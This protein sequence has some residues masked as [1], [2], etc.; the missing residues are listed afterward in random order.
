MALVIV[1]CML[2]G[3][4][5]GTAA[6][7][8]PVNNYAPE[9]VGNP[10]IGERLVCGA[11]SWTGPVSEFSYV[12]LR[13]AIP[14]GSGV[15]YTVTAADAGHSL[16][17]VVTA[18]GGGGSAEAES[19]NSLAIPGGKP[20]RP[21]E[22]IV[23]PEVSG[24]PALGETLTCLTGTWSGSPTPTFT[25]LWVREKGPN[26][27]IIESATASTYKVVSEDEGHSLACEV[28]ATNSS[29]SSSKLSSNE[30]P[31]SGT[32]PKDIVAPKLLGVEP[33]AVGESLTCSPGTWSGNPTPAFTYQWLRDGTN[34]GSA[35]GSTYMVE[36]ADQLHSLS[37]EVIATNIAGS[38][39]AV[40][41]VI[42]IRGRE[43]GNI[44]APRIS[45][46]PA[47]GQTLTCNEGAWTGVPAPTIAY[48]WVRDQGTPGEVAIGGATF[49]TYLVG[50]EDR[51]H[52][53]SCDVTATNSEGH[54]SQSSEPVVVPAGE[55]GGSPPQSTE[56][57]SVSGK[58]AAGET[59]SCSTGTWSGS[60][61]PTLTYQWLRDGSTI[62][63]ATTSSHVVVEAD[64]GH[65]LSCKVTA[66]NNE[67]VASENSSPLEI[68]GSAPENLKE[69]QVY[70]TPAVGE[71][72]ACLRGTW[73]GSPTPTFTYLWVRDE[74]PNETI[75]E[76]ATASTY[77]VGSEDE[78]HSLACEVTATNSAGSASK[79]SKAIL[80]PGRGPENIEAPRISGTP[81][82]G[83]TLTC[84][85]GEWTGQPTPT[86]AYRWLLN[87]ETVPTATA[88][89]FTVANADRGL[90]LSCKVIATNREGTGSA[91]SA[92]LHVPGSRPQDIE[93]PQVSGTA[94][95]GQQLTCQR[96]IWNGEPPPAFTYQ[97]LRDGT[98]IASATSSTYTVELADEGHRL[99]CEVTATNSEGRT[100]ALSGNSLTISTGTLGAESTPTL[101][102]PPSA[103]AP[104]PPTAAQILAAV[105]AQLAHA[106]RRARVTLLRKTGLYA[107]SFT[108][109]VAGRLELFWYLAP[110]GKSH[111]AKTKP[112][113]LA[114]A[115]ATFAGPGTKK[116]TLR[117]TSAGRSLVAHNAR[118][119][120]MAKGAFVRPHERPMT[121]GE[122]VLVSH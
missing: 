73:S 13:D 117:L 53:L 97:W 94:A 65:S 42:V 35:T 56:A 115:S 22:N 84:L 3:P 91:T 79:L 57:P 71:P 10:R 11:G 69:P 6:A 12:W 112:V 68:P 108:A 100:E 61:T 110:V 29:G 76:S 20:G 36:P 58:P 63:A 113:V 93:A 86:Y 26:E 62:P 74:G 85:R 87:G 34:I 55:P 77:K 41:N 54:A 121:W 47:A 70:G 101:T 17:C 32:K 105:G 95:V 98:S 28:T 111:S 19:S 38:A 30:L 37:C 109:P 46:T 4:T 104:P 48:L 102:F 27:T 103:S 16:W 107:F 59:L 14:V 116:V 9:V 118:I 7:Q 43:P 90:L 120:L 51:G 2:I 33:P 8:K 39:E 83:A 45:G 5:V 78:G 25:Y 31:V 18:T 49:S 44:E 81:A 60:P 106:Q 88:E 21:P 72:L 75:I 67:G 92:G 80:I 89:T 50:S 40:S 52:S 122:V 82:V 24:K 96:G 114:L 64:E 15:T 1:T 66:I 99:S 119:K 23:A